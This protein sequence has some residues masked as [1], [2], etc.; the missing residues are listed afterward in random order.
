MKTHYLFLLAFS[1]PL[2]FLSPMK[3]ELWLPEE[4]K[5]TQIAKEMVA[6]GD[7][8]VPHLNDALYTQKPPLFFWMLAGSATLFG[9]WDT[10]AMT[11]PATC[12][13]L[14]CLLVTYWFGAFLFQ[15]KTGFLSA[16]ILM[17][18]AL[19]TGMGQF[20]RMDMLL[21]LCITTS[22]LSFYRLYQNTT[23]NHWRYALLFFAAAAIGTLTKGPVGFGLPGLIIAVF[24]L[25]NRQFAV[26]KRMHLVWGSVLYLSI[27]LAWFIPAIYKEG[28]GY[29]YHILVTQNV[30]RV[31]NSWSHPKPWY[32]Y[33]YTFPWITLPWFFYFVL[34][35]FIRQPLVASSKERDKI[36]FLWTW[37]GVTFLFFSIVSGKLEIYLLPL[38]P[39]T[40]MLTA[41]LW[42]WILTESSRM[43]TRFRHVTVAT[44]L[45]A[46]ILIL[47]AI[48]MLIV[49]ATRQYPGGAGLLL[50]LGIALLYAAIKR[51]PRLIFWGV[52]SFTPL[53]FAYASVACIPV[54][55]KQF[56]FYP[57]EQTAPQLQNLRGNVGFWN[58]DFE[59]LRFYFSERII[60]LASP[61]DTRQFFSAEIP[62]YCFVKAN[63]LEN[64]KA[65]VQTPLS[66]LGEYRI[67]HRAFVLVSQQPQS[68]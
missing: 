43:T 34:A 5:Y 41:R 67:N 4:P 35:A 48:G 36:R 61:E 40:A 47:G 14:L 3:R 7:W 17:T 37:W 42:S 8:V 64:L 44:C 39:P 59:E 29:A 12:C 63:N 24:L 21:L 23:G 28:W 52:W 30:G 55:N 38:F 6:T 62:V 56:D 58:Y 16:L 22:L 49:P 18:C 33:L 9:T 66:V 54:L 46:M 13:A 15:R 65:I 19:F 45:F 57:V 1:I 50:G 68:P 20:V 25:W 53:L 26:L 2:F 27:V 31:Y 10:P 11:F 60:F 51:H 32:F